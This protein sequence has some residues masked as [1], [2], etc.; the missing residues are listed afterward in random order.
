MSFSSGSPVPPAP[1]LRLWMIAVP[2]VVLSAAV[3]GL[4]VLNRMPLPNASPIDPHDAVQI[5]LIQ[6]VEPEVSP[7]ARM[8]VGDLVDGYAHAPIPAAERE[9]G[10]DPDG[11][12]AG[13]ASAWLEPV[14]EPDPRPV[15]RPPLEAPVIAPTAPQ[16]ASAG[17]PYGFDTPTPDYDAARRARRERLDRIE[18]E[19]AGK[20]PLNTDTAFY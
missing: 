15:A 19:A 20:P 12:Q 14:R 6:P 3:A 7:G 5:S 18:A 17:N 9:A 11:Y 13:Y 1:R 2:V 4:F 8:E 10:P 16:P